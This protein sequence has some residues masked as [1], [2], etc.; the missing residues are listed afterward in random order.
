MKK[1]L[2]S[3]VILLL[4]NAVNAQL[5]TWSP[6]FANDNSTI[7]ITV[8]ATKGNQGL[9]GFTGTVYM[10]LGV[11]TNLSTSTTNWRYVPTTWASTTAPT[12]TSLGNNKW[13][14]TIT[15]PRAYFNSAAGGVPANETIL[16][17][18]LLFRDA[19]GTKVQKNHLQV[20]DYLQTI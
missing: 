8:D 6:Q 12:A 10:H 18:A 4:Y 11:I 15:N 16:K 19:A 3:V 7:T 5:L 20:E 1:V 14:F 2:L 13:S 9:L 17:V